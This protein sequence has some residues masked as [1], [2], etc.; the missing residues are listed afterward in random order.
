MEDILVATA[1]RPQGCHSDESLGERQ[2]QMP[3]PNLDFVG[4]RESRLD[5]LGRRDY[6]VRDLLRGRACRLTAKLVEH[7]VKQESTIF[8]DQTGFVFLT[9][10]GFV[11]S[12]MRQ[13]VSLDRAVRSQ[14]QSEAECSAEQFPPRIW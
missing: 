4:V 8:V 10:H 5:I 1:A 6:V 13:E 3:I 14:A 12:F 7:T 11:Q 9:E 2:Q